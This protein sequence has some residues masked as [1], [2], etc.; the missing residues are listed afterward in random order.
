MNLK[1]RIQKLFR[2]EKSQEEQKHYKTWQEFY[3]DNIQKYVPLFRD[4]ITGGINA[5]DMLVW[6]V[7]DA[8]EDYGLLSKEEAEMKIKGIKAEIPTGSGSSL[9]YA[10]K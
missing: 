4:P 2:K 3:E 1:Q 5:R 8:Q 9:N 7:K 6:M 10:M